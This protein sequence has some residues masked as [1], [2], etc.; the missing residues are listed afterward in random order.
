LKTPYNDQDEIDVM[1]RLIVQTFFW[2][3]NRPSPSRLA[4]AF[5]YGTDIPQDSDL[6]QSGMEEVRKWAKQWKCCLSY[7]ICLASCNSY[8]LNV[9]IS[10]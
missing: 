9:F 3:K 5:V 1:M 2:G 4:D 10:I 8:L 6:D 7:L